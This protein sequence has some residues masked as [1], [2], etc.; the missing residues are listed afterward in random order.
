MPANQP[1]P[2]YAQERTVIRV[3]DQLLRLQPQHPQLENLIAVHIAPAQKSLPMLRVRR[4]PQ[5]N[6]LL[7]NL[8]WELL[9]GEQRLAGRTSDAGDELQAGGRHADTAEVPP[10]EAHGRQERQGAAE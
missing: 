8:Q 3:D 9:G 2:I 10:A 1:N 4:R 5:E 7:R 6:P